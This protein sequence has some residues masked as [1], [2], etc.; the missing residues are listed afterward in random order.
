MGELDYWLKLENFCKARGIWDDEK[1][2]PTAYV[3]NKLK[4]IEVK[5]P[6]GYNYIR[7]IPDGFTR[8]RIKLSKC[9]ICFKK[10]LGSQREYC[11]DSCRVS[12]SQLRQEFDRLRKENKN[13][14]G[15]FS[16][17]DVDGKPHRKN[18]IGI[19]NKNGEYHEIKNIITEKSGK[20]RNKDYKEFSYGKDY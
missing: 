12:A 5:H 7:Q 2:R 13:L 10:L 9:R 1:K 4:D 14:I 3:T 15:I 19:T 17:A 6:D 11:S 16:T 8:K 18:I 20:T